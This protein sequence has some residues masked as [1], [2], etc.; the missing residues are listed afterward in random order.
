MRRIRAVAVIG[1]LLVLLGGALVGGWG[2]AWGFTGQ[3]TLLD[4]E[5]WANTPVNY[6]H[7]PR[8]G[9]LSGPDR[10]PG[11]LL[12]LDTHSTSTHPS[13]MPQAFV[14]QLTVVDDEHRI[15]KRYELTTS[16]PVTVDGV[17]ITQQDHGFLPVVRVV[18]ASGETLWDS[19]VWMQRHQDEVSGGAIALGSVKPQVG[20]QLAMLTGPPPGLAPDGRTVVVNDPRLAKPV[21]IILP[22]QGDVQA[23]RGLDPYALTSDRLV[24]TA[25]RP[26]LVPIGQSV[27]VPGDLR[28]SFLGLRVYT[29]I[30]LTNRPGVPPVVGLVGLLVGGLVLYAVARRSGRGPDRPPPQEG[31]SHQRPREESTATAWQS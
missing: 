8:Y 23:D 30:S 27:T 10:L 5:L 6:D 31:P 26:L 19:P 9:P 11:F 2:R 7:S 21:L 22:F 12:R 3:A 28:V 4:G 15:T 17:R 25:S 1:V 29:V 24:P 20:L 16:Q 13:G 14:S 18:S